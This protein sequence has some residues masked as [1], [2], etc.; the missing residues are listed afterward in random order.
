M[1]IKVDYVVTAVGSGGTYV[2]LALGK[3]LYKQNYKVIGVNVCDSAEIFNNIILKIGRDAI[4]KFNLKVKLSRKNITI[5]DGYVGKGYALSQP[6]EI[7]FIKEIAIKEALILD[8]VYTGKA[9]FGLRDQIAMG[10]IKKGSKILFLH[11]G[12]LFGIFPKRKL[13]NFDF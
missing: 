9:M 12:G 3:Q 2:G 10:K 11:T 8:P 6:K 1:K 7:D 13:F 4:K 5:I